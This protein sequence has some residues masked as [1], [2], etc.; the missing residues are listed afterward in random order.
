MQPAPE[1]LKLSSARSDRISGT[2]DGAKVEWGGICARG[3]EVVPGCEDLR[4]GIGLG[5]KGAGGI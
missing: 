5:R 1:Q 2:E 4:V 3:V